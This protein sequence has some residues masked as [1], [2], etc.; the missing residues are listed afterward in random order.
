[1]LCTF[2]YYTRVRAAP[3]LRVRDVNNGL[4]SF[5]DAG[6]ASDKEACPSCTS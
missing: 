4:I 3:T 2:S 1:M 5:V 6:N